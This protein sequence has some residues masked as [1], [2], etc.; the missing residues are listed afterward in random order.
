MTE[1]TFLKLCTLSFLLIFSQ[2]LWAKNKKIELLKVTNDEDSDYQIIKI[3]ENKE[4]I[5]EKL[6]VES[7]VPEKKKNP[8][9]LLSLISLDFYR[10]QK[11]LDG[12][13]DTNTETLEFSLKDIVHGIVLCRDDSGKREVVRLSC[14]NCQ[15]NKGGTLEL[16][17]L[18]NGITGSRKEFEM[19]VHG[20][21]T[22]DSWRLTIGKK[23]E[24]IKHIHMVSHKK[25][26]VGTVGIKKVK[27]ID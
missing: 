15:A 20:P 27:I 21:N 10:F 18:Y 19:D 6:I 1:G 22:K 12:K 17:Y 23:E 14:P 25:P 9:S 13:Q 5:F 3:L 24:K 8:E 2:A 16:D 26:F 7:Y 11:V 4:G